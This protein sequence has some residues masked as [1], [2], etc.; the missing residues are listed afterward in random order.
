MSDLAPDIDPAAA[1]VTMP[2]TVDRP[3]PVP[4][5]SS[6][7]VKNGSNRWE[8]VS[9]SHSASGVCTRQF[10]ILFQAGAGGGDASGVRVSSTCDV[11]I[12]Q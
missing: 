2:N 8:R 9:A 10:D 7:V 6:L 3:S 5:S 12:A 4:L 1:R 11:S